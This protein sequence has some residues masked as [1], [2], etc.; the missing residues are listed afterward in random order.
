MIFC[1]DLVIG[2]N[3]SEIT[4]QESDGFAYANLLIL[5]G[6]TAIDFNVTLATRDGT[7]ISG[8]DGDFINIA[9]TVVF[10]PSMTRW[11]I[12]VPIVSDL[13]LEER[14]EY[15]FFEISSSSLEVLIGLPQLR[16][17]IIDDDCE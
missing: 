3:R 2:F 13:D 16:M 10:S 1:I 17:T 15:F 7:A 9:Q 12:P 5:A 8:L 6:N 11:T 4:V 14:N